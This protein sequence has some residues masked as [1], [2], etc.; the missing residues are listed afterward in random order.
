[1]LGMAH[2]QFSEGKLQFAASSRWIHGIYVTV[3]QRLDDFTA[4]MGADE[5]EC[6]V[7]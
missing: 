1:V 7:V 6:S 5:M 3:C 2:V 4:N